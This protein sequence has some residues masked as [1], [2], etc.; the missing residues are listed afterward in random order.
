VKIGVISDTH[1]RLHP[2]A[3]ELLSR[4]DHILHAGDIGGEWILDELRKLAPLTAVAGNND[5]WK[6]GEA[7]LT[8]RVELGGLRF[9][10]THILPR[11][12]P[13]ADV[14]VFGHSH[15]PHNAKLGGVWLFNP[16]SAG[17]RRFDYPVAIGFFEKRSGSWRAWHEP[18]DERSRSALDRRMNHLDLR[19]RTGPSSR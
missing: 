3:V 4:A 7:G 14:L 5:N 12:L 6:C 16:A 18:L 19:R 15:L 17:P 11:S 10:L 2:R 9:H 1:G 8:A 13:D